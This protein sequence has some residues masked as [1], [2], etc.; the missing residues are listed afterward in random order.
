MF[1]AYPRCRIKEMPAMLNKKI[2]FPEASQ[3]YILTGN[4]NVFSVSP[5]DSA[6]L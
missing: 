5:N 2:V 4:N 1:N 3:F 6:Q